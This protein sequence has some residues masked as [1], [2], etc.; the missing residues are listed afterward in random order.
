MIQCMIFLMVEI[1]SVS[2]GWY[3]YICRAHF[4]CGYP[5]NLLAVV[6]GSGRHV[7]VLAVIWMIVGEGKEL[8]LNSD[9]NCSAY[10]HVI[11]SASS[12]G[13]DHWC[14]VNYQRLL[15]KPRQDYFE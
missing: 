3:T 10:I 15:T 1:F 14:V 7:V 6:V 13:L 9:A 8:P 12:P 2:P 5:V 11:A 4:L